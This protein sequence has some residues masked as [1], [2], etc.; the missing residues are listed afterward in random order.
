MKRRGRPRHPDILTP[1]EW[2]VLALLRDKLAN[3]QIAERLGITRDAVKYHVSEILSKLGVASREEAAL[4]RP[5]ERPWWAA[6]PLW[7]KIAGAA[8]VATV[9]VACAIAVWR[10]AGGGPEQEEVS[11]AKEQPPSDAVCAAAARGAFHGAQP[12][13][14]FAV[15]CPGVLPDGMTIDRSTYGPDAKNPPDITPPAWAAS[16]FVAFRDPASG[17]T[18][19]FDE[20]SLGNDLFPEWRQY[21]PPSPI[22]VTYGNEPAQL[23]PEYVAGRL[24]TQP[25]VVLTTLDGYTYLMTATGVPA[26]VIQEVSASMVRLGDTTV[27]RRH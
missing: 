24:G 20:G 18:V 6:W 26:D 17:A 10:A 13:L 12:S 21:P 19:T 5:S 9:T 3:P 2:E 25:A 16:L 23:H 7:A 4:W 22:A 15:F 8:T 11:K 1:R 27:P 14:P